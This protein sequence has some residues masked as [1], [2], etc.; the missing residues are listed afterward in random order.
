MSTCD[1][2]ARPKKSAI[3]FEGKIW[4]YEDL[5]KASNQVAHWLLA[6]GI[7]RQQVVALIMENKPEYVVI[8]LGIIK[9]GVCGTCRLCTMNMRAKNRMGVAQR[10]SPIH[11]ATPC[12]KA[13]AG[14]I[15]FNLKGKPLL[16]SLQI[17]KAKTLIVGNE[18]KIDHAA[19]R[20]S[21]APAQD[22]PHLPL[23]RPRP[24][25]RSPINSRA[26][27]GACSG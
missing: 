27:A 13:I 21:A 4:T 25:P 22:A 3:E 10:T 7:K 12:P 14:L 8:W 18:V 19:T 26:K 17:S 24:W 5:D 6:A 16:H 20:L 9:I 15:N 23:R 2:Q 1:L 11:L